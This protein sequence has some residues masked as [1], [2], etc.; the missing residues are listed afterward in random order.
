MQECTYFVY[1]LTNRANKV[2]YTGITNNLERRLY[3]HRNNLTPGFASKYRCHKLLWYE[4]TPDVRSAIAREKQIKG[5][6][7]KKKVALIEAMNP[8]WIDLLPP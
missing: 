8:H 6:S 5:G 1:I 7:R 4:T 3:E 2:L